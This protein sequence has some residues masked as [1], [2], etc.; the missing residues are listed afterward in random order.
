MY[1]TFFRHHTKEM[2][3]KGK[4]QRMPAYMHAVER[5][6]REARRGGGG[7]RAGCIMALAAQAQ[8]EYDAQA[9]A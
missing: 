8:D 1:L 4:I 2:P 5:R 6:D 9:V 7:G 3:S